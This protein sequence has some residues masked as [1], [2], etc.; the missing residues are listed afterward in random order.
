MCLARVLPVRCP[1]SKPAPEQSELLRSSISLTTYIT[2]S[3]HFQSKPIFLCRITFDQS[4]SKSM[5][6]Q[7][8]RGR[9]IDA[10]SKPLGA[11]RKKRIIQG[12]SGVT[13]PR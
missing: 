13:D 3:T 5:D 8:L 9:G 6:W 1:A 7:V 12:S 2:V 10:I 4:D 11:E